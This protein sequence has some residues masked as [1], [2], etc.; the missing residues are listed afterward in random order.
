MANAW[1]NLICGWKD[2]ELVNLRLGET[3]EASQ[4]ERT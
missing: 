1:M 2:A 3:T 4:M